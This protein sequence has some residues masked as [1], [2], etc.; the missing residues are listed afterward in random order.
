MRRLSE[1]A[2]RGDIR[3]CKTGLPRCRVVEWSI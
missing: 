2:V 1:F 3:T